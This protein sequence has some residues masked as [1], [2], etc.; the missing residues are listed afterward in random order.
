M[1]RLLLAILAAVSLCGCRYQGQQAID[2]FW[3]RKTV[4]PPPTGSI[5]TCVVTPGYPAPVTAPA[6]VTPG[7]TVPGGSVP[8][9]TPPNLL[10]GPVTA[11]SSSPITPSTPSIPPT[12][13]PGTG[14][15]YSYGRRRSRHRRVSPLRRQPYRDRDIRRRR[16]R[17]VPAPRPRPVWDRRPWAAMVRRRRAALDH[18]AI[19]IRYRRARIPARRAVPS[20]QDRTT[21][22]RG[23]RPRRPVLPQHR[24]RWARLPV[25]RPAFFHRMACTIAALN[26][27]RKAMQQRRPPITPPLD[28]GSSVVRIP[29]SGDSR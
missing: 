17:A 27:G 9:S 10:P 5:G 26:G 16:Q 22:R 4:P 8:L 25:R 3:G 20:Q 18:R 7:M 23:L 15:P 21:P 11:P 12:P 1:T 19:G 28:A 2:P 6:T 13:A 14:G 29:T 24:R